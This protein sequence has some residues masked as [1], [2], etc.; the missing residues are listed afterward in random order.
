VEASVALTA[1]QLA[2]RK[3]GIG[4][5][6]IAE[7][8]SLSDFGSPLDVYLR[9]VGGGQEFIGNRFTRWG[10]LHEANI[11]DVYQDCYMPKGMR[12]L[13]PE[14]IPESDL[15]KHEGDGTFRRTD[16]PW[17]MCTPDRMWEDLSRCVEIK[18]ISYSTGKREWCT[19]P[20]KEKAPAKYVAQARYQ[21][22]FF[23]CDVHLV[24]LIG[25][26]NLRVYDILWRD[27]FVDDMLAACSAFWERVVKQEP[28]PEWTRL[29]QGFRAW[30]SDPLP[31]T[32]EESK[33]MIVQIF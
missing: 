1:R 19:K 33:A 11:A 32:Y 29:G 26:N 10:A 24:P 5:S 22:W 13:R 28:D 21:S 31:A 23:N 12:L 25:G 20:G 17:L 6:E 2:L 15:Y 4:G 3:T 7:V 8:M 9:K 30:D 16:M 27:E 18:A 14:E